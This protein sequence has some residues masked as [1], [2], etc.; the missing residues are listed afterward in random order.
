MCRGSIQMISALNRALMC[1][2]HRT[3]GLEDWRKKDQ[4]IATFLLWDIQTLCGQ[5][6]NLEIQ[7]S[8]ESTTRVAVLPIGYG[9]IIIG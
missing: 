5:A 7:S 8:H 2:V 4:L 3:G 6:A 1:A 9:K